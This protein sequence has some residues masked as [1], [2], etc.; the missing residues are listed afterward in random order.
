MAT[1]S[2]VA[3]IWTHAVFIPGA[4]YTLCMQSVRMGDMS[5]LGIQLDGVAMLPRWQLSISHIQ[6]YSISSCTI[7]NLHLTGMQC[8]LHTYGNCCEYMVRSYEQ[9]ML[10]C[11]GLAQASLRNIDSVMHS[12]QGQ[13]ANC[14]LTVIQHSYSCLPSFL[15]TV[16][17]PQLSPSCTLTKKRIAIEPAFHKINGL[18]ECYSQFIEFE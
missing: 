13:L 14:Q 6:L 9:E 4:S 11:P 2:I 5:I 18:L 1:S 12:L 17:H 16:G 7:Y 8:L 10:E 3:P 15:R